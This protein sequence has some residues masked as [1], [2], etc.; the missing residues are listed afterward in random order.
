MEQ[1][2]KPNV[3]AELMARDILGEQLSAL[4]QKPQPHIPNSADKGYSPST[5]KALERFGKNYSDPKFGPTSKPEPLPLPGTDWELWAHM[6]KA[7]LKEVV[8]VSLGIDPSAIKPR[9]GYAEPGKKFDDLLK[10]ACAFVSEAGPLRPIKELGHLIVWG[11]PEEATVSLPEFAQWALSMGYELPEKFPRF[12]AAPR[13]PA[14]NSTAP[15]ITATPN[16][17]YVA[18]Q[19]IVKSE[20]QKHKPAPVVPIEP[21]AAPVV[22]VGASGGVEPDAGQLAASQPQATTPSPA[23][24]V[25]AKAKRRTWR[26]AASPYIVKIMQDGQY[27]TAKE[28]YRALE[29]KAGPD[30]PLDK[31]TGANRGSLFVREIAQSLSMKTVQNE[32]QMLR[33]LAQK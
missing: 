3:L 20:L 30:S 10:L 12:K 9:S 22:A 27:T 24:V 8:A 18:I 6:P 16:P 11:K 14:T 33:E 13:Q 15:A 23:P 29:A 5:L 21:H 32:W 7:T 19:Q 1:P 17:I 28:L 4:R 25:Q 26:D 31:G 2:K